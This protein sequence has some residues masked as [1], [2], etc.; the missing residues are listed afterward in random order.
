MCECIS[1]PSLSWRWSFHR[2]IKSESHVVTKVTF[3]KICSNWHSLMFAMNMQ[4]WKTFCVNIGTS[5]QMCKIT[6][7]TSVFFSIVIEKF[8]A[9]QKVNVSVTELVSGNFRSLVRQSHKHGFVSSS[10]SDTPPDY[11][12]DVSA[13][14]RCYSDIVW[15][16]HRFF[17]K[18]NT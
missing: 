13:Y 5:R 16:Q 15:K 8:I 10:V 2:L 17:Y 6:K 4:P 18:C 7:T 1:M 12:I 3:Y 11:L 14:A 9:I